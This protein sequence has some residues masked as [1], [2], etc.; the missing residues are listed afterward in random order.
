MSLFHNKEWTGEFQDP[1]LEREFWN[2]TWSAWAR[3]TRYIC[4][5]MMFLM[6]LIIIP[7]IDYIQLGI[8]PEFFRLLATRVLSL[9]FFVA[10]I[11]LS[12]SRHPKTR[13]LHLSVS[14]I[15]FTMFV[16]I[17]TATVIINIGAQQFILNF[18]FFWYF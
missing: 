10:A 8:T 2:E 13:A 9:P 5:L 12:F 4:L 7:R 14:L 17:A 15:M 16:T 11:Y 6:L 1:D 3:V 18:I